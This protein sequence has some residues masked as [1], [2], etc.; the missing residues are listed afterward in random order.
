MLQHSHNFKDLTSQV[1]GRLKALRYAGKDK[2]GNSIWRCICSCGTKLL[3]LGISLTSGNTTSCGCLHRE[4]LAEM[5]KV[6][7]TKHGH[8]SSS[9]HSPEYRS[10]R[11]TI[12]RC[13]NANSSNWKT[14]G[15]ANPPVLICPEWRTFEGFLA[16]MGERSVG[17][18]L[19]RVLDMGNYEPGN[20]FWQTR[21]EQGL[22]RRNK[23]SLLKWF[24]DK[25]PCA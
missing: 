22:S 12:T 17:T 7:N 2:R 8:R 5:A 16:S 20:A 23:K 21:A 24:S 19:G 4:Q 6:N 10:W 14:Y 3:V 13:T 9:E 1:F 18:T 11:S 15:G 25:L